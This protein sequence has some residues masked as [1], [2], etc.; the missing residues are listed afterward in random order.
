MTATNN[1]TNITRAEPG[2]SA[3]WVDSGGGQGS[4]QSGD[5]PIDGLE[6]R[7]RRIDGNQ[8]G[9]AFNA[10]ASIDI[11][12]AGTHVGFW[13]AVLQSGLIGALGLEHGFSDSA[14]NHRSGNWDAHRFPAANFPVDRKY[15][16]VWVD[17]SRARETGSGTL[18]LAAVSTFGCEFDMGNVG[19]TSLNCQLDRIDYGVEGIAITGGS[20]GT[21]ETFASAISI[22]D[23]NSLGVV[24]ANEINAPVKIGGAATVFRDENFAIKAGDQP[25]AANDWVR[26]DWDATNGAEDILIGFGFLEGVHFNFTGTSATQADLGGLI[27]SGAP[28]AITMTAAWSWNGS[29]INSPT[30]TQGGANLDGLTVDSS[31]STTAVVRST[32]GSYVGGE[33]KNSDRGMDVTALIDGNDEVTIDATQFSGNTV[34][35]TLSHAVDVVVNLINGASAATV[36]NTGAGNASI[37]NPVS[38][39]V[40]GL[41]V[42]KPVY[43]IR[44]DTDEVLIDE[45]AAATSV[46]VAVNHTGIDIPYLVRHR[47]S[48]SGDVIK[49]RYTNTG[50]IRSTGETHTVNLSNDTL[51]A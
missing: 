33:V 25:L 27:L 44:T 50:L 46:T 38:F 40:D 21:P 26:I 42:G 36:E 1:L 39:T 32:T 19:G 30:L 23:T 45:I 16:R 12:A 28:L 6:A 10:A 15:M 2:D 47:V 8:R 22:S 49:K 31:T 17:V 18:N 35:I 24:N 37:N 3:R 14:T 4:Q 51:A 43:A 11:S 7:G 34:D 13:T 29:L 9:F 20:I 5:L 48:S 41:V